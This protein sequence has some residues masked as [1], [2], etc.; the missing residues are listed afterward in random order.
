MSASIVVASA[1]RTPVGSFNGA[2]ANTPAHDLGAIVIKEVLNRAGVKPEEVDEGFFGQ[3]ST[4]GAGQ[5]PARQR[6][7]TPAFR[8][9]RRLGG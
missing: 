7:A 2:F 6:R 4:A 5:N 8:T 3:I 9:K 1:V